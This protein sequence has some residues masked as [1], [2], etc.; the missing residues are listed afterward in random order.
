M[1]LMPKS[2]FYSLDENKRKAVLDAAFNEFSRVPFDEASIKN[3]INEAGIPRGSFYQ[4]FENKEDLYIYIIHN[5]GASKFVS[6]TKLLK[7][8]RGDLFKAFNML[9]IQEMELF[10]NK[11]YHELFKNFYSHARLSMLDKISRKRYM[12]SM[13]RKNRELTKFVDL[14]LYKIKNEEV[15]VELI[16]VMLMSTRYVL[17]HGDNEDLNDES[18]IDRYKSILDILK[19]GVCKQ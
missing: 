3:I 12:E 7:D 14:S 4:Y 16:Q 2:T 15:L 6:L 9:F 10:K 5:I 8:N 19:Y 17:I 13:S 1:G 11:K 18:M